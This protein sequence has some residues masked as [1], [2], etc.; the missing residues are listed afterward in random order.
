MSSSVDERFLAQLAVALRDV[1]IDAVVVG[2]VASILNGSPVLTQDVNLLVRDT[3]LNRKKLRSLA[4]RL[5]ATGP[6]GISD[7]ATVERIYGA[8]VPID[9]VFDHI[10]GRLTFASVR[11]RARLAYVGVG[12]ET[13][14]VATLAD[15]IKSKTA[16]DRPKDR[17]VLPI[18]RDTL[19]VRRAQGLEK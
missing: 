19:A 16:A 8:R 15:V 14:T 4:Q 9:I 10:P 5:R 2:N 7:L 3:A 13:L 1:R 17:A 11:S 18:L 12:N 6:L